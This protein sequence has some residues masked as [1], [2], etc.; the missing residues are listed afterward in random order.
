VTRQPIPADRIATA[1]VQMRASRV[2][3]Q[4]TSEDISASMGTDYISTGDPHFSDRYVTRVEAVTADQLQMAARSYLNRQRMITTALIPAEFT[5]AGAG[6]G[7]LPTAEDLLRE[8][9]PT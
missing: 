8:V 7:G 9:A 4:Q 3:S 6:A 1:K 2:K 5:G